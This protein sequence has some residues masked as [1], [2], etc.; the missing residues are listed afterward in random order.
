MVAPAE[1]GGGGVAEFAA[2]TAVDDVSG[3]P[4][5]VVDR[6]DFRGR[7]CRAA[8]AARAIVCMDLT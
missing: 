8:M 4:L 6:H 2:D 1:A 5:G 7:R 3:E